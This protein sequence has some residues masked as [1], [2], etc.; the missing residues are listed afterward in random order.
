ME[1]SHVALEL[2]GTNA[3]KG[4]PIAVA[5]V[6][7]G[8]NLEDKAREFRVVRRDGKPRND[9]SPGRWRMLQKAIEEQLDAKVVYRAPEEYRGRLPGHD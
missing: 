3:D 1:H 7:I 8:L 2:P 4:N 6:H 5:R 9:T